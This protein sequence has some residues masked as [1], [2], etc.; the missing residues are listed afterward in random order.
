M[1]QVADLGFKICPNKPEN[2][3]FGVVWVPGMSSEGA[4]CIG[5][6]L[7]DEKTLLITT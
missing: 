3:L 5:T 6:N 4:I 7:D 2:A 1:L